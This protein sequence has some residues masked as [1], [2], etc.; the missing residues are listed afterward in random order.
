MQATGNIE[1]DRLSIDEFFT[2]ISNCH[3][4]PIEA[5]CNVIEDMTN[6]TLCKLI[7]RYDKLH[8]GITN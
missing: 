2:S 6:A 8:C 1:K 3:N 5:T 4:C 7:N